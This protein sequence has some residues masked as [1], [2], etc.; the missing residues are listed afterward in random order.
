M[1][2]VD[3]FCKFTCNKMTAK[4]IVD[5]LFVERLR[6]PSD[7]KDVLFIL[8]QSLNNFVK[9]FCLVHASGEANIPTIF[10]VEEDFVDYLLF[11]V[12]EAFLGLSSR[13]LF[14]FLR[15]GL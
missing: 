6:E 15:Q 1:D 13:V 9:N 8:L 3:S 11:R 4:R 12:L 10:Q 2:S 5:F 7:H 14:L